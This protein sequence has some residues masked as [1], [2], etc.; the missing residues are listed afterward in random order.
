MSRFV[1]EARE[2]VERKPEKKHYRAQV[3]IEVSSYR[4]A[5]N[6]LYMQHYLTNGGS[7]PSAL[8]SKWIEDREKLSQA[9]VLLPPELRVLYSKQSQGQ[10]FF[11]TMED[12]FNIIDCKVQWPGDHQCEARTRQWMLQQFERFSGGGKPAW[13]LAAKLECK[14]LNSR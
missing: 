1:P 3:L 9:Y 11:R 10:L 13:F 7:Y 8:R 14:I 12:M 5:V 4:L 6:L 2:W